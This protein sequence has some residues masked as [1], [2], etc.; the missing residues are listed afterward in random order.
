MKK[1]FHVICS[2]CKN[3]FHA[4]TQASQILLLQWHDGQGHEVYMALE[5]DH[6]VVA[7]G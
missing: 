4:N 6:C 7:C 2:N 3:T 5:K 1:G